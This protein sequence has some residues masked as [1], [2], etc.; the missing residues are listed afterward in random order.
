[1]SHANQRQAHAGLGRLERAAQSTGRR[2]KLRR[3]LTA[4]S[5]CLPLPLGYAAVVLGI[6]KAVPLSA[7][8]AQPWLWG[9]LLPTAIVI[10][11]AVR[12]ALSRRSPFERALALDRHHGLQDRISNALAFSRLPEAE[13]TPLMQAA[14]ADAA[15]RATK[16]E[17]SRAARIV[18]PR[19]LGLSGILLLGLLGLSALEVRQLRLV[20]PPVVK[21]QPMLLSADDVELFREIGQELAK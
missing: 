7:A 9:T 13:R 20:P 12:A 5:A 14:I 4:G 8:Q 1:M 3:A 2:L 10:A 11:A 16:L 19:E 18:V 15:E 17:P 21:G 6:A